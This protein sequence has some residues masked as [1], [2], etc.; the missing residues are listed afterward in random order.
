MK[1]VSIITASAV[2]SFLLFGSAVAQTSAPA[3]PA[4]AMDKKAISK[5]CS[6]QATAKTLHGKE[7]QKF[8]SNCIKHGGTPSA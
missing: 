1:L 8:R 3:T 2:A 5:T 7:R 4:P 6:D